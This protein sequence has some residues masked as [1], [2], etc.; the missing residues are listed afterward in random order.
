MSNVADAAPAN[1]MLDPIIPVIPCATARPC[2]LSG[3]SRRRCPSQHV[4][5]YLRGHRISHCLLE[6]SS[7][8]SSSNRSSRDIRPPIRPIHAPRRIRTQ[9]STQ[10]RRIHPSPMVLQPGLLVPL[11]ACIAVSSPLHLGLRRPSPPST[12]AIW[13]VCFGSDAQLPCWFRMP[14]RL[15]PQNCTTLWSNCMAFYG[16]SSLTPAKQR[17][18]SL[19]M[20][21]RHGGA[22]LP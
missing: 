9:P 7:R 19:R 16:W 3:R 10:P 5:F 1:L 21:H 20:L 13:V 11:L 22:M 4:R 17:Q 18:S 8:I 6:Q 12:R 15:Y 2:G 14:Q